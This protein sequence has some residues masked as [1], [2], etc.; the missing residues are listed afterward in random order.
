MCSLLPASAWCQKDMLL[1]MP[2]VNLPKTRVCLGSFVSCRDLC[3]KTPFVRQ[4]KLQIV[5][6]GVVNK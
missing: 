3:I 5:C 2:G 6:C 1:L 4:K